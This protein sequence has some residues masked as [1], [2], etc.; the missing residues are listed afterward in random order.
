MANVKEE[1][2]T[3]SLLDVYAEKRMSENDCFKKA[4]NKHENKIEIAFLTKQLRNS[5]NLSQ[6]EFAKK[7]N[8]PQSTIA[9][10]ENG[11]MNPS[12]ELLENIA[13]ATNSK[14]K[15]EFVPIG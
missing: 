5:L 14:L 6:R 7:V 12:I 11:T 1:V 4:Y 3:K 8:K 15:I 13:A 2:Q 9:R 10:I